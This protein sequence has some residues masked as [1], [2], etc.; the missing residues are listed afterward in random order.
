MKL[1]ITRIPPIRASLTIAGVCAV[2]L[3][4]TVLIMSIYTSLANMSS[5]FSAF[6]Y[7]HILLMAGGYLLVVYFTV[8]FFCLIYNYI[9]KKTGGLEIIVMEK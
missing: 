2:L 1:R 8:V 6:P 9:A 4:F 7:L 3:L 5:S